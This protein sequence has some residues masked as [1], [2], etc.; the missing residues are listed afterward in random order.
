MTTMTRLLFAGG[1]LAVL[2]LIGSP[3]GPT[4]ATADTSDCFLATASFQAAYDASTGTWSEID[5]LST[6]QMTG[7]YAD[8]GPAAHEGRVDA[9]DGT[10]SETLTLSGAN[11]TLL[12][13]V[14]FDPEIH[15]N[16]WGY[17]FLRGTWV[18]VDGTG[19]YADLED[20]GSATYSSIVGTMG[21]GFGVPVLYTTY[22][23]DSCPEVNK[24]PTV[25]LSTHPWGGEAPLT[26]TL[27]ATAH[28]PDGVVV[29]YAWDV[30]GDGDYDYDTGAS[31]Q[32]VYTY[33]TAGAWTAVVR[34]TDD[35]GATATAQ[36][37]IGVTEPAPPPPPE[38]EILADDGFESGTLSGGTG[39]SGAWST[40]GTVSVVSDG[41]PYGG[42]YHLRF[43]LGTSRAERTVALA[44]TSEVTLS[45][46]IRIASFRKR[47]Q[48]VLRLSPDGTTWTTLKTLG[49]PQSD[50][51]YHTYLFDLSDLILTDATCVALE[52]RASS[53]R[54]TVYLDE[55]RL[56]GLP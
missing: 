21:V 23:L 17:P 31:P 7:A 46:A 36:R 13:L 5:L 39:W 41:G 11:G 45:V 55:V 50:A 35:D 29:G 14:S 18:T 51:T 43:N 38:P 42:G 27:T 47:D 30:D 6:F 10:W 24:P 15:Y 9:P 16:P 32:L 19:V 53:R 25:L 20:A 3:A 12:V 26:V 8:S 1:A 44:D 28:D 49:R 52:V 48:A 2:A 4:V 40:A 56:V 54:A 34:A 22:G 37:I 33:E